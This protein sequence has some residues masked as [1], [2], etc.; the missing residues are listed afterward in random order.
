MSIAEEIE[1][2]QVL[3]DQGSLSED[4]FNEAKATLLGRL[5]EDQPAAHS[6]DLSKEVEY[7]RI[8]NEINQLD[9]AWEHERESYKVRGRNGA[10]YI[11][12]V[13]ISIITTI[14]CIVFGVA[15]IS[16]TASKGELGLPTFFGLLII[17]VVV[18][19]SLYDYNKARGYRQAQGRYQERRRQLASRQSSGRREW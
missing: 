7:L 4:E 14:A 17:F 13:P 15:W 1:K 11:P 10:R 19:R 2:L 8:E 16:L 3:H 5:S 12:S 9:L 6:D 18:G